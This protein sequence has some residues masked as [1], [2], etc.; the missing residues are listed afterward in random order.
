MFSCCEVLFLASIRTRPCVTMLSEQAP[1]RTPVCSPPHMF[2]LP[3]T[4]P[5]ISC[6]IHSHTLAGPRVQCITMGGPFEVC[7]LRMYN[8]P[9]TVSLWLSAAAI[10]APRFGGS[11]WTSGCSVDW[12]PQAISDSGPVLLIRVVCVHIHFKAWPCRTPLE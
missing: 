7:F 3:E 12:V 1:P 5:L 6:N 10:W 2:G 9:R 11:A 8:V 4:L